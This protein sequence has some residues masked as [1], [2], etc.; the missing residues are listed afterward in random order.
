MNRQRIAFGGF[1]AL[2]YVFA[3]F[4]P[5][6]RTELITALLA[7]ARRRP[8]GPLFPLSQVLQIYASEEILLRQNPNAATD[9][10]A[11]S[12]GGV[13]FGGS[14]QEAESSGATKLKAKT[15]ANLL[16]EEVLSSDEEK[17]DVMLG[18]LS[19]PGRGMMGGVTK[20][21]L[22]GAIQV[23]NKK[24]KKLLFIFYFRTWTK[25][26]SLFGYCDLL[27]TVCFITLSGKREFTG[28]GGCV[29]TFLCTWRVK[30]HTW[31]NM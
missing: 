23:E 7:G 25:K 30:S 18:G 2:L 26:I 21:G 10:D 6:D 24:K 9:G 1:V 22:L 5:F 29:F 16:L 8:F 19:A 27:L 20:D 11:A 13:G 15:P 17:W 12:T 4:S 31:S 28:G 14:T 3:Y